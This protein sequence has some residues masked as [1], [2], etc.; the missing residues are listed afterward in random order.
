MR[1]NQK[2]KEKDTEGAEPF[3][4]PQPATTGA[5]RQIS[6]LEIQQKE[7]RYA[8][9]GGY[10]MRDVDEFLDRVTEAMSAV[11]AENER[12]RTGG[13]PAPPV[14]GTPDLDDVGRQAD[15]I[16]QRAR[17]EAERIVADGR[18]RAASLGAAAGVAAAA[19]GTEEE[20]AA[21]NAFLAREK[22]FLQS[23]AGLVQGHAGSVKEMAKAARTRGVAPAATST[24]PAPHTCRGAPGRVAGAPPSRL[25]P[26]RLPRRRRPS[27]C[28]GPRS[29]CGWRS[30]PP[31]RFDVK[32]GTTRPA[33]PVTVPCASC[34]GVRSRNAT[35]GYGDGG[36]AIRTVTTTGWPS[37][38]A[39]W[40]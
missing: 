26:R 14:L 17:D 35:P 1:N 7:F 6:P 33:S 31:R 2:E 27:L 3:A 39:S 16:I 15:E 36:R 40:R 24:P 5:P 21:I 20:R 29:P 4:P 32:A 11:V 19:G 10:K 28:H 25:G 18:A 9:F 13:A 37:I 22:E 34:S 38:S 30:P 23:L 8:R 12:L